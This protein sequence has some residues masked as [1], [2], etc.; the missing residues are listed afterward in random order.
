[1]DNMI[2]KTVTNDIDDLKSGDIAYISTTRQPK[3]GDIVLCG[4]RL[5]LKKHLTQHPHY[6]GLNMHLPN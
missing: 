2:C 5:K 1:M 3:D 4:Q 6:I